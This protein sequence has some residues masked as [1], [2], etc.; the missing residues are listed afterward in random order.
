MRPFN[1]ANLEELHGLFQSSWNYLSSNLDNR[2]ADWISANMT[3]AD[4]ERVVNDLTE[5][6]IRN[7]SIKERWSNGTPA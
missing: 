4:I 5:K 6:T 7:M 1:L 3:D 2:N